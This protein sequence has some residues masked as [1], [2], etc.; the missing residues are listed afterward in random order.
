MKK[1]LRRKWRFY[2]RCV[3]GHCQTCA[4]TPHTHFAAHTEYG[5]DAVVNSDVVDPVYEPG[6]GE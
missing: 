2:V 4:V 6:E 1:K 3:C 5:M